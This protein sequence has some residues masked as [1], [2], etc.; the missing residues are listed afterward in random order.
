M[1]FLICQNAAFW[2]PYYSAYKKATT[3]VIWLWLYEVIEDTLPFVLNTKRPLSYIWLLSYEQNSFGFFLKKCKI[4]I[5]FKN[6]HNCF[7]YITATKYRSEAFLYSKRMAR[8]PPS[9]HTGCYGMTG[10]KV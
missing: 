3:M 9:P 1:F 6:T 2:L 8:Y 4:L 7:A 5:A 10:K